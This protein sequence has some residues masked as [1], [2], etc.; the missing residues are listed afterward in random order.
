VFHFGGEFASK[1]PSGCH[2]EKAAAGGEAKNLSRHAKTGQ[3][4]NEKARL[5]VTSA[6]TRPSF[7]RMTAKV[8]L[9]PN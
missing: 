5:L 2:L 7:L 9:A 4:C 8:E 6:A 3:F 1:F